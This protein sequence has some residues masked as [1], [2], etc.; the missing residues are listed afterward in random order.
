M[1]NCPAGPLGNGGVLDVG[2]QLRAFLGDVLVG[3][4]Q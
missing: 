2:F 4:A 3:V 1:A